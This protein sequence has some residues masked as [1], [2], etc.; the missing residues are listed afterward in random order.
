[1]MM[2][3]VAIEKDRDLE[4]GSETGRITIQIGN[5]GPEGIGHPGRGG[6]NLGIAIG[7]GM[8]IEGAKVME[9]GGVETILAKV[10]GSTTVRGIGP[11]RS[12]RGRIGE[13]VGVDLHGTAGTRQCVGCDRR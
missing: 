4:K 12:A 8:T 1:M 3:A 9:T 7:I 6:V 5:I 13:E 2:T 10:R 11:S